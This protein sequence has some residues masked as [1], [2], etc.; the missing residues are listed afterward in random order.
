M[1]NAVIYQINPD[2]DKNKVAFTAY[3]K[4][5]DFQGS[6][7]I[8]SSLYD[9]VFEGQV[10]A[11]DLEDIYRI[12]NVQ[13]P[14]N[15]GGRSMSVSDIV[16]TVDEDTGECKWNYCDTI[17]FKEVDFCPE[18]ASKESSDKIT[19]VMLEPGEKAYT[20][21]VGTKLGELQSVV[22][23]C[24]EAY[25]PFEE[26]VCIVCNDEGKFN[27]MSANRGIFGED[28]ELMDIIF[29]PF[30][31]CDCSGDNFGSLSEEQIEKYMKLYDLPEHFIK[32][33]NETKA[34][35]YE[36]I[37]SYREEVRA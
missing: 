35:K 25:Y 33:H 20:C 29:G 17:G 22:G 37:E 2:R 26:E 32:V 27:G 28:G 31:I 11:E 19:V 21:K 9:K 7:K 14:E 10:A 5:A 30:F 6:A 12:F 34:I 24:I 18:L 36:P 13:Q 16:E 15:Y 3:D 23:G 4:L 1:M 8:D